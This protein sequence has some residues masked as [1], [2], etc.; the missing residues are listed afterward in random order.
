M[1]KDCSVEIGSCGCGCDISQSFDDNEKNDFSK[2]LFLVAGIIIFILA[3][4]LKLSPGLL[5]VLFLIS[6]ILIGGDVLLY[7]GKNIAKGKVFDENFLMVIATLGAFL[8]G[9]YPEAVAVMLFYK[10]GEAFQDRAVDKS[11]KSIKSL[12]DIKP[13]YANLIV[14]KEERKVSPD[15]VETGSI[16]LIKPGERVPLD[17]R[18]IEGSSSLDTSALTGESIPREVSVGDEIL[19]GSVNTNGL[20]KIRT[21]KSFGESTVNKIIDL[22][23]HAGSKKAETEKFITKFAGYYTPA[24]VFLAALI[25]IIPPLIVNGAEFYDWGYRALV[26]LVISCPCALVISI[27]LGFFGGIGAASRLGIL[28][29]GGNYLEALNYVDTVIFDKTG[30]LTKGSFTVIETIP[31]NGFTKN[32]V[33][34]YAGIAESHSS[35][36]IAK[37]I[38]ES[39][40][41][42]GE[43][44]SNIIEEYQE[45]AG[46][47]VKVK[48]LGKVLH[49]G[50]EK[51]GEIQLLENP[52]ILS[53]KREREN[54]SIFLWVDKKFAGEIVLSDVIKEESFNTISDL[55]KLGIKNIVMLTGDIRTT[56]D[57]VGKE[58]GISQIFSQLLPQEKL[59]KLEEILSTKKKNEKVIFIGDGINDSPVLAR[60][61]IG[62][63]MGGIG[64]D[65]AIEA[66]DIVFM[67][68]DPRSLLMALKVAKETK[69]IVWQNIVMALGIKSVIMI[70]GVLGLAGMWEAVFADVGVALIA[71]LNSV[72]ILK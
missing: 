21:S 3:L 17:G 11:K 67:K 40:A 39:F 51:L 50:N 38:I 45:I 43:V 53:N 55:K 52:T 49:L 7:A 26:F 48:A 59:E 60:A 12:L 41:E 20:L 29:K 66:A 68:D 5:L 58:L 6:Y 37:S 4:T 33:L 42:I 9:E 10:I 63:A 14:D 69:K 19:S 1:E 44:D 36:P 27:P 15:L 72:R 64:S 35:H 23:Q 13:D 32:E 65:A 30:T 46:Q 71:I 2:Y 70:L 56:A 31:Y 8:I 61:D 47:G 57:K 22:V 18:I 62:I 54:L 16:I 34:K 28:V 24:V 25:A